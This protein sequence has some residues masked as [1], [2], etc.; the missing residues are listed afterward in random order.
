MKAFG[1]MGKKIYT[2]EFGH[3]TKI[4]AMPI[5][6]KTFKVLQNQLTDGLKSWYE[7]LDT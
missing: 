7:A 2:N 1:R 3:M 5:Y 6:G 4:S